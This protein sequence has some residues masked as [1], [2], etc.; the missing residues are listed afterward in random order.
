[1]PR[2]PSD[3]DK[4]MLNFTVKVTPL[5]HAYLDELK[6]EFDVQYGADVV[7]EIIEGLRT[8]FS[9]PAYQVQVLE[10][11]MAARKLNW[12]SY[13]QEL[14]ARRYEAIAQDQPRSKA[15]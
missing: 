14:L 15:K 9:L 2:P 13:M 3:P 5:Q 1:M 11:D 8:W 10:K 7:R 6:D 4:K 12:L